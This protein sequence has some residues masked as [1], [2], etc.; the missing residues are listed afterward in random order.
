MA[1]A[2]N[3]RFASELTKK[4][5][6]NFSRTRKAN[7]FNGLSSAVA[8]ALY[9]KRKLGKGDTQ[10]GRGL[11]CEFFASHFLIYDIDLYSWNGG[12]DDFF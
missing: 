5:N 8:S 4:R 12:F 6:Q 1:R 2:I 7:D 3:F 9:R 11:C 10:Q